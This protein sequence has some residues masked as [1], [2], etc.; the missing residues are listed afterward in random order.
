MRG[1]TRQDH[2]RV[3]ALIDTITDL[4]L[5]S[6]CNAAD[7]ITVLTGVIAIQIAEIPGEAD[8]EKA[9]GHITRTLRHG[10]E[11]IRIVKRSRS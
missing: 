8:R 7:T 1:P 2:A 11:I 6:G 5:Q 3:V 10:D 9:I 4:F